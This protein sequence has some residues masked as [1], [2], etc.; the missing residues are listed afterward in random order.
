M[1]CLRQ[2][3]CTPMPDWASLSTAMICS[4]VSRLR[5]MAPSSGAH[6]NTGALLSQWS[7]FRGEGQNHLCDTNHGGQTDGYTTDLSMESSFLPFHKTSEIV[8]V[9]CTI[10]QKVDR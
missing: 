10:L 1:P 6:L 9:A 4:S 8:V 3:S 7:S 5:V 2:S